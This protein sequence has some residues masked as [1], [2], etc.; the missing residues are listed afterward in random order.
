M[1]DDQ[2]IRAIL[3]PI[4]NGHLLLPSNVV[5]EVINYTKPAP[6][7]HGPAWLLGELEWSGWRVPVI[8]FTMLSKPGER[9]PATSNSRI[10]IIKTLNDEVSLYYLGIVIKGLPKLKKLLPD[11]LQPSTTQAASSV[12]FAQAILDDQEAMI[13]A[14]GEFARQV[15]AAVYA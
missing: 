13:P 2:L 9:D 7:D 6:F 4:G 14:L 5:S 8:N 15:A 1:T 3:A 11:T 12:V 10:L